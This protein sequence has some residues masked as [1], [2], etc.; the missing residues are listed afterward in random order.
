[1]SK[2]GRKPID[3]SGV[4]VDLKGQEVHFKGPKA[5]GV[6]V[7]SDI[8]SAKVEDDKLSFTPSENV[9]SFKKRDIN[10]EWGMHRALLAN[11]IAGSKKEFEK[12]V[13]IVG[14]GYKA[15]VAGNK[16]VF[17]LGYSHDIDF[18]IPKGVTITVDKKGQKLVATSS[19]RELLGQVCSQICALR[20]PEPY[21]GTGVK[22]STD[23]IFRKSAKGK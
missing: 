20:P 12:T 21:K 10:R 7:F 11:A 17:T 22:L 13:E 1:M 2:I 3:I 15:V 19:D 8:L 4:T 5:A 14:L 23:N 6:Y 18:P 16:V 9:P